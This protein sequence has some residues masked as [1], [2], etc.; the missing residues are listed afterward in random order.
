M[1][2]RKERFA[3]NIIAVLLG[4][5]L[6]LGISGCGSGS[7][8]VPT[9]TPT[10]APTP[11]PT[12]AP[13]PNP[14]PTVTTISPNS[15]PAGALAFMLTVDGA[16]FVPSSEVEWNGSNRTTTF[17]SSSQL[18]AHIMAADLAAAGKV[19]VTVFNPSLGGGSS[20]TSSFTVA[21]DTIT[22]RSGR[23]LD[24]SDAANTNN[25]TNIWVMNPDG[26]SPTPLTKLTAAGAGSSGPVWSP[27]GSKISFPS[28]RA[29]DGSDTANTNQTTNIWV[30]NADG[31]SA[32]PLTKL[33]A[34]GADSDSPNQP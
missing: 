9:P 26:S 7:G 28:D 32:A 1:R 13:T 10:P 14:T 17:V 30:I 33:T 16:N 29:L 3:I 4:A 6:G 15:A 24:G 27:D 25:T 31:S 18:Q 2:K 21:T 12:P 23:A 20:N 11:T 34:S 22:F 19:G 8:A 5:A